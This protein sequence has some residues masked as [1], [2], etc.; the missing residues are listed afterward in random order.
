MHEV[1]NGGVAVCMWVVDG[2]CIAEVSGEGVDEGCCKVLWGEVRFEMSRKY[3][4]NLQCEVVVDAV[5]T[6]WEMARKGWR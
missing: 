4:G 3:A 6:D 5:E 2:E 1:G